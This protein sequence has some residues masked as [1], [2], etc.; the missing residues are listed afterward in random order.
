MRLP[1]QAE[2]VSRSWTSEPL[3]GQGAGVSPQDYCTDCYKGCQKVHGWL[4][5]TCCVGCAS[6]GCS[7]HSCCANDC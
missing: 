3:A 7:Y 2:P 6:A 4:R 5:G 1:R